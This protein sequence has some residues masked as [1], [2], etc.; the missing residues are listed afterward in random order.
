[1][2][3]ADITV[4]LKQLGGELAEQVGRLAY[5]HGFPLIET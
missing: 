4:Q 2:T 1:M 3:E 5:Q